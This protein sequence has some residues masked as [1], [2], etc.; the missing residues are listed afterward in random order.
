MTTVQIIPV[1]GPYHWDVTLSY[2]SHRLIPGAEDIRDGAFVR[3]T[4]SGPISVLFDQDRQALLVTMPEGCDC[5][6]AISRI[7]TLFQP[8]CILP[9][10]PKISACPVLGPLVQ[11]RPGLRPLGCWDAFEL[12][13]R[14]VA[15]QQVSVAAANT[16]MAR[17]VKRCDGHLTPERLSMA[18]LDNL[19]VPGRRAAL[20]QS[21]A[22]AV[23]TGSLD[24]RTPWERLSPQL[25]ALTGIGPWTVN[26]LGI[27]LGRD[28]DA[29]PESDIGLIRA[30][31]AQTK[32]DLLAMAETWRPYRGFAATYLWMSEIT[33]TTTPP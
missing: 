3:K 17:L 30:A 12:L 20:F 22:E 6:D 21:L 7:S 23:Q 16:V 27:R 28:M 9:P 25:L 32:Q 1:T 11:R 14:T 10:S 26:Y 24:L 5:A 4:Q 19:G 15:G 13:I 31:G 29:F 18:N 8:D 2:F 33:E